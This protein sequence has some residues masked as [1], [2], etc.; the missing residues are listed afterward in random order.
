M[1]WFEFAL[2]DLIN[3]ERH[4]SSGGVIIF[5]DV[6]PRTTDEAARE[7]VTKFWAGDVFRIIGVLEAYR[8]DLVVEVVD[9]Q[10]TGL[11]VVLSRVPESTVLHD[12]Y[13][14]IVSASVR[15]DP[16]AVPA[17]IL[18]RDG[19]VDPQSLL[20]SPVW[21][22][23]LAARDG[24]LPRQDLDLTLRQ[25]VGT[26]HRV[27][28]GPEPV[29][30]PHDGAGAELNGD[31]RMKV[32]V[33]VPVYN[34]GSAIDL[35][36][37]SLLAQ[38][39]EP[40]EWEAVFVDDGSTDATP[41]RLDALAT[42]H[43]NISVIHTPNWGW[44]GRPRNIGI[45]AA[46]GE[47]V[48]FLDQ[49][50][51]LTPEALA[52]QVAMADRNGS[53]IVVGKEASDF[54]LVPLGLFRTNVELGTIE[55]TALIHSLTPHKMFRTAF[56]REHDLRFPEGRRRLEDQLFVVQAY[57]RAKV[58]SILADHVVR[59]VP[60]TRRQPERRRCRGRLGRATTRTP[61]R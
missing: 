49:D 18:A 47:Y 36:I 15:P 10:P 6:L 41:A 51:A 31:G 58:I 29:G 38:T 26:H 23:L 43:P 21:D 55:N 32:T 9:T 16:Q 59:P 2:R 1:H 53:D 44:A 42:E 8:P 19:A 52:R 61:A 37:A 14:E 39:L 35:C 7:R 20:A 24:G 56:L 4:A 25:S 34:P 17:A 3:V 27:S 50:D 60:P 45:D 12:H 11:L 54:R 57:F 13:D 22:D 30:L 40:D 28:D 5:D 48:Q 33:V 46:R